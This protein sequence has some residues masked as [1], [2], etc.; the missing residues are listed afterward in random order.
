MGKTFSV[1][2]EPDRAE[3]D[4]VLTFIS[5]T[6]TITEAEK[7]V[8]KQNVQERRL[9]KEVFEVEVLVSHFKLSH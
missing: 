3:S 4:T 6:V 2:L 8:R 5:R 1:Q 9:T 7:V